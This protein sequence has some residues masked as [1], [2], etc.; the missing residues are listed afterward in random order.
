M[1]PIEMTQF[2]VDA[3]VDLEQA[4]TEITLGYTTY[5]SDED[6]TYDD[7]DGDAGTAVTDTVYG[8]VKKLGARDTRPY[9]GND[10]LGDLPTKDYLLFLTDTV[11][12][13]GL[14]NVTFTLPDGTVV[15]P[16]QDPPGTAGQYAPAWFG[17]EQIHQAIQCTV[18]A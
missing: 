3:Q 2:A 16:V 11:D 6:D 5:T 7:H 1:L 4:G 13:D 18:Q 8:Y 9:P 15:V 12:L 14:A 10:V 17:N